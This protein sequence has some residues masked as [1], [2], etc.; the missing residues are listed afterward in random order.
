MFF[1]F[2]PNFNVI[3]KSIIDADG[4]SKKISRHEWFVAEDLYASYFWI[5]GSFENN[6]E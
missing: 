5:S 3:F 4:R 6:F 1:Q 2:M